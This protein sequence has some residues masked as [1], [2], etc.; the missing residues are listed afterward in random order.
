MFSHGGLSNHWRVSLTCN[1]CFLL[2]FL[3]CSRCGWRYSVSGCWTVDQ[4]IQVPR[5]V[6]VLYSWIRH[7]QFL[8]KINYKWVPAKHFHAGYRYSALG[9]WRVSVT[10]NLCFLLV[11]FFTKEKLQ[12]FRWRLTAPLDSKDGWK[13]SL[14]CY[15]GAH[16]CERAFFLTSEPLELLLTLKEWDELSKVILPHH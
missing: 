13:R 14:N 3:W 11:F 8:T 7:C 16:F 1:L 6:I 10:C 15:S 2:V 5:L 12:T 9:N 4:V